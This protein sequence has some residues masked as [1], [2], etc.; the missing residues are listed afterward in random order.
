MSTYEEMVVDREVNASW[1]TFRTRLADHLADLGS[2]D[3]LILRPHCASG[4]RMPYLRFSL[5]DDETLMAQIPGFRQARFEFSE[6]DIRRL[7]K[8]GTP[9]CDGDYDAVFERHLVD[10]AAQ[11]THELFHHIWNVVHPSFITV[12]PA[13]L[14]LYDQPVRK[15]AEQTG[16]PSTIRVSSPDQLAAW[17]GRVL[18]PV[19]G[20]DAL[21]AKDSFIPITRGRTRSWVH[22]SSSEPIVEVWGF[23]ASG[24]D[25]TKAKAWLVDLTTRH[26]QFRF[27]IQKNRLYAVGTVMS[28]PFVPEQ[29]TIMVERTLMLVERIGPRLRK[30]LAPGPDGPAHGARESKAEGVDP[31]LMAL[32]AASRLH[33]PALADLALLL[34]GG[35]N[36]T[37]ALWRVHV[38]RAS[39]ECTRAIDALDDDDAELTLAHSRAATRWRRLA[40]AIEAA[41]RTLIDE[42]SST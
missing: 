28:T 13:D 18:A 2:G 19:A 38:R 11:F 8:F 22:M 1:L 14:N 15:A 16:V 40:M 29:L 41:R 24:I 4:E 30:Q 36:E 42:R 7:E 25:V 9:V 34:S 23:V 21:K 33:V 17:V 32:F 6:A 37:L 5:V 35:S 27:V 39:M 10:K 3:E 26:R 31:G 20:F 12:T